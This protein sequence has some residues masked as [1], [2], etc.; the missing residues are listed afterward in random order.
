MYFQTPFITIAIIMSQIPRIR[1]LSET[2][3]RSIRSTVLIPDAAVAVEELVANS[4]D[5]GATKIE[6]KL[7]SNSR[8][9]DTVENYRVHRQRLSVHV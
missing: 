2:A 3:R 5:A 8:L 1:P 7:G 4:L 9:Y 6:V